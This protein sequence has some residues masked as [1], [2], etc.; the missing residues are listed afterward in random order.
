MESWIL[1]RYSLQRNSKPMVKVYVVLHNL[2]VKLYVV[3]VVV[4]VYDKC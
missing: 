2:A 4:Y 3:V 1:T